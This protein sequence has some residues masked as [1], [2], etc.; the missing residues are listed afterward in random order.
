MKIQYSHLNVPAEAEVPEGRALDVAL[1]RL[2]GWT[3]IEDGPGSIWQVPCGRGPGTGQMFRIPYYQDETLF[4]IQ[5]LSTPRTDPSD[6]TG[7]WW[8]Q[9]QTDTNPFGDDAAGA[10]CYAGV[11]PHG[12][13]GWN[14]TPDYYVGATTLGLAVCQVAWLAM[15]GPHDE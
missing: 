6:L 10:L 14:G 15:M 2:L 4:L 11:T 12:V 13:T 8:W 3:E 1:A 9:L 7:G 5:R